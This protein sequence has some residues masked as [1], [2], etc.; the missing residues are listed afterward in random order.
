MKKVLLILIACLLMAGY[1]WAYTRSWDETT[2][3]DSSLAS[4]I[5]QDIRQFKQDVSER[6]Q[7]CTNFGT[8]TDTGLPKLTTCWQLIGLDASLPAAP[9]DG[10]QYYAT[11][12]KKW[13][14]ANGGAWVFA[15]SVDHSLLST[16]TTGDPHTQ[17]VLKAG[18]TSTGVQTFSEKLILS[19][20]PATGIGIDMSGGTFSTAMLK[21]A[22]TTYLGINGSVLQV[23]GNA[24]PGIE[25]RPTG[26]LG[27]TNSLW[28]LQANAGVLYLQEDIG[29]GAVNR[30]IWNTDGSV[31]LLKRD[32]TCTK[33]VPDG[34]STVFAAC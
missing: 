8:P 22:A 7:T 25:A 3:A 5:G 27:A 23:S 16:L 20:T 9:P 19:G 28:R 31:Q 33:I 30:M 1:V 32:G 24:T 10:R 17:Y 6:L 4:L 13:Y 2:P 14:V 12:T 11:D 15:A 21:L 18:S 29:S 26:A 34:A